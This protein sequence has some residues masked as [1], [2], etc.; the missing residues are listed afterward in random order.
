MD[1]PVLLHALDLAQSLRKL[2]T[3]KKIITQEKLNKHIKLHIQDKKK[4]GPPSGKL[5][6][7]SASS[8]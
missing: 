2:H 6:D 4:K 8:A 5:M 3:E 7:V 1:K